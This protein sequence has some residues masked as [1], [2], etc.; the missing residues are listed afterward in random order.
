MFPGKKAL[1]TWVEVL[2]LMVSMGHGGFALGF[3]TFT[4][5]DIRLEGLQRISAGTVFTYLPV[6]A[7]DPLTR[8][9]SQEAVRELFKTGFFDDV[10]LERDGDVLVVFLHERPALA[11]VNITGNE[12]IETEDLLTS[13]RGIG[14]AEGRVFNPAILEQV[15]QELRRQYISQGKYSIRLETE[16]IPLERNR[17]EL[18][19]K[20]VEGWV[21]KIRNINIVGNA[22]F[23]DEKLLDQ[24]ESGVPGSFTFFSSKDEYS[25][26]KL[27][28]DL[29]KLRSYYLD[30]G[31]LNFNIDSTQVSITPDKKD[32]YITVNV[33]EGNQYAVSEVMLAGD[34]VVAESELQPL[35]KI[36]AGDS[37]SRKQVTESSAALTERLGEDGFAF[38]NINTI[39]EVDETRNEVKLTFFVDPGKR[40]FVRR[41]SITGNYKTHDEVIRRELR[42]YEGAMLSGKSLKLSRERLNRLGYFQ[43]VSIET[44]LVPGEDDK[45]DIVVKVTETPSGNIVAS[46]GYSDTQG[47]IFNL[48][49]NQENFLGTGSKVGFAFNNSDVSKTYSFSYNNPYYTLDGVSRGFSVYRRET[50]AGD[51][52]VSD[53]TTDEIGASVNYG[54][55]VTE[56]DRFGLGFG[57][58]NTALGTTASTP[59][60]ILEFI[61]ANDDSFDTATLTLSWTRDTRDRAFF[62]N[63]GSS[64]RA[65]LELTGGDIEYYK[66]N[67]QHRWFH[68]WSNDLTL[69]LKGTLG[70]GEGIGPTQALPFYEN[71][72]AG[73]VSSVRGFDGNSL[74]PKDS[75]RNPLGGNLKVLGSAELIFLP[76]WLETSDSVRMSAFIDT[77]NV[78]DTTTG[79]YDSSELRASVGIALNWFSPIGPIVFSYAEPIQEKAGDEIE[80]FQ[81]TLGFAF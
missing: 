11:D 50:D 12:S 23:D 59:A 19:L 41:I 70:F 44:P 16:V 37:F 51:A 26:A 2:L 3:E 42:Q 9:R 43:D 67:Y 24:F 29:E 54:I 33:S 40:V 58:K 17:V 38:S 22:A 75:N 81:F 52:S 8:H 34:L 56:F 35:L 39:P 77:G 14:L 60:E 79:E 5:S 66:F 78:F 57:L 69:G 6:K 36:Q 76:P 47:V 28:G 61:G 62:A 4:V 63:E 46:V 1:R 65:S 32:I 53:Y 55:P 68:T 20:I 15:E 25:R 48:S 18:N 49:L 7:G 80:N 31:F 30:R 74:G 13:L 45:V 71:Y 72:Y 10:R 73:G 21:A 27:A 64:I